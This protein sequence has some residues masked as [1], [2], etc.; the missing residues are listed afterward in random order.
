M[1]IKY[2]GE[3]REIQE[4]TKISELFKNEIEDSEFPVIG[5]I[6]NNEYKNLQDM[7][8][9][10][11]EVELIDI[12][13]KEGMKMY[14][15]TLVYIACKAVEE[16]YAPLKLYVNYQLANAM[17]CNI[18]KVEN[19]EEMVQEIDKKMHEIVEENLPIKKITM[20]RKEAKE[21][22]EKTGS[23]KGKLQYDLEE[24]QKICMYYCGDYYNYCYGTLGNR[25]GITKLFKL[26]K[27]KDGFLIKYPSSKNPLK[28]PKQLKEKKL[29]WAFEEY[30]DIH[31]IL[32]LGTLHRL[33]TKIKN[34]DIDETIMLA[35][36]LH[37]KKIAEIANK[38]AKNKNIKMVL[39]AG[40]S[41]SGK[42][43]FAQR[44]GLQ[45]RLN[46]ITPVTISVDNYFVE[47]EDNPKDENG[48]YDFECIEAVDTKLFNDHLLRLLNGEEVE[49]PTFNFH[50]GKKEYKGNK[51]KLEKD[52]IL[53]IEGIHCLNDKLTEQIPVE[54]KYKVYASA[55]T[56]LSIDRYNRI[57]TTDTRL[58]RR[59][60]RDYQ[61]RG[62][63]AQHTIHTWPTVNRGEEKN[64]FPFQEE[65][66][67]IFN[68]SLIYEIAAL[69]PIA[70]PLLREIP[71]TC[72][73]YAEAKRLLNV[74]KYFKS[75]PNELIPKNS[76]LKEFTGGG[77]FKY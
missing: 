65:A 42:T 39:I 74:L 27:Y 52:Q 13:S 28:M 23:V 14:R 69:K 50:V 73:E 33:N 20:N 35:E 53:V 45:L 11:S 3:T 46:K 55:L 51:L 36:A 15:R 16:L 63:D 41:S 57:S 32:N 43:T 67:S 64:I 29:S 71:N 25:T 17:F 22:Y 40:P 72:R 66:N 59:I 68:T 21:F 38:V 7:I 37:E 26:V 18:D 5:S 54:Q 75:I 10:D 30:K 76:I 34:G 49:M 61:F 70:E 56:V 12:N 9:G 62:Y 31:K 2:K 47:R 58:I 24:N 4:P 19:T 44:L 8:E 1:K 60:V 48:E 77:N 6:V